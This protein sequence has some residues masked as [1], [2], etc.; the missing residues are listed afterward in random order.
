MPADGKYGNVD[1]PGS[2]SMSAGAVA[3]AFAQHL[4]RVDIMSAPA[5]PDAELAAARSGGFDYLILPMVAHWEDRATEWSGKRDRIEIVLR[6]T[7]VSDGKSLGLGSIVGRSRYGSVYSGGGD[8]PEDLLAA[9][10]K[11]Y[12]DSLFAQPGTPIQD[13]NKPK[14]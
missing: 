5:S 10:I 9:P 7:R 1:Y 2:G 3:A 4:P 12:V 13:P 6:T 14:K 11:A 8:Q